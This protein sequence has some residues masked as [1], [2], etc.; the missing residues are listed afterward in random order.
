MSITD[1]LAAESTDQ[2][3]ASANIVLFNE[4]CKNYER[5][6]FPSFC[7]VLS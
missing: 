4:D 7:S 1:K 5:L 2:L 6:A 3:S